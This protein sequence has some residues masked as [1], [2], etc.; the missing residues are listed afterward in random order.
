MTLIHG[1]IIGVVNVN[2]TN[3]NILF[4]TDNKVVILALSTCKFISK[5]IFEAH[6]MLSSISKTNKY[7]LTWIKG[8][9]DNTKNSISD[10]WARE[11]ATGSYGPTTFI[12]LILDTSGSPI[13]KT[14]RKHHGHRL[15]QIIGCRQASF[16]IPTTPNTPKYCL[17]LTKKTYM[18][19]LVF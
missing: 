4:V 3:K 10:E 19:F 16:S 7:T 9:E 8:Y 1:A 12:P 5:L 15:Q 6:V 14:N 13:H 2:A 18:Y 11:C 17:S